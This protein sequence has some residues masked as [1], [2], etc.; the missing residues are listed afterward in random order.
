M[1]DKSKNQHSA[2]EVRER[3]STE[4]SSETSDYR[5]EKNLILGT[6]QIWS[7]RIA[8]LQNT[9]IAKLRCTN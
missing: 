6:A 2:K 9:G 3:I 8:E 1:A 7:L 5:K 4:K